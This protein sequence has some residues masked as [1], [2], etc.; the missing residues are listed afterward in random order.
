ML[1][2]SLTT[3]N[4]L[5]AKFLATCSSLAIQQSTTGLIQHARKLF[6]K[7][8][9]RNDTYI[10]NTMMKGY[11][12]VGQFDEC[13]CLY[14]D[15]RRKDGF[16]SDGYTFL[17]LAKMCGV[18]LDVW[19]GEQVHDHVVK[20]GFGG[21]LYVAT[22]LVDMYAKMGRVEC[23]KRVFDEMGERSL[24]SWTA[25]VGGYAK[26]GEIDN[27]RMYFD[28]MPKKDVAAFNAMIDG[29]VKV[30]DMSGANILFN[31]MVEKNVVSWTSMVDGYCSCGNLV[32][33]RAF[34]DAMPH[35]N[36]VSWNAMIKGYYQ[37][38]QPNE[39][40]KLFQQLQRESSLEP[41][42]VT[43]VSIL[44]AIADMGALELGNWVHEYV[45]RK[46]M[47]TATN[48]CTSLVDMYAKCGEFTKARKIFES[49]PVKETATW[50]ALIHGLAVNGHGNEAIDVFLD[51]NRKKIKPN[52]I[53][54]TAVL[55]ACTHSGLVE[56]GKEW[57]EKMQEF[58]INPRIEHYGCMID[59]L[60]RAGCLDEAEK[61]MNSMP[62]EVNDIILSS[63][64]SACGYA[65]DI[66]RAERVMR[67]TY[68]KEFENDGNY[69][70]LRNLYANDKR[71]VDVEGV[72]EM[73][74][75]RQ[76]RKEVGCSVIEADGKVWGFSSG[77]RFHPQWSD[78]HSILEMLLIHMKK[79]YLINVDM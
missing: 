32:M 75:R 59:L 55:S 8:P 77:D 63:F 39:A 1:R 35:K 18:S 22:S 48:V 7:M 25:L 50:N 31:E 62:F 34:F 79:A 11:M 45:I 64:L 49:L 74:R 26:C 20:E 78:I 21:D 29:Y 52:E 13:W 58:G 17:T 73:M 65:K 41:N 38:K 5:I 37:N 44:P 70:T 60:G 46:K 43:I 19:G 67:K 71:W 54:M 10:S 47:N 3:N 53:T 68:G 15:L 76:T 61:I 36:L 66:D 72:H 51:M 4:N 56:E 27:A 33:A 57:F 40:L 24:V 23:A 2:N 69:I 9:E 6:D 12:G 28:Q 14:R 30:G 42:N 16:R